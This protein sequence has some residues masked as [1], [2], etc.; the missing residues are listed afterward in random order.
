MFDEVMGLL[1]EV[2]EEIGNVNGDVKEVAAEE[3]D[4]EVEKV[5]CFELEDSEGA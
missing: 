5:C 4:E 3:T 2:T 1:S